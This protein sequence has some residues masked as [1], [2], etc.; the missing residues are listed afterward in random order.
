[1][2]NLPIWEN[3]HEEKSI[4]NMEEFGKG[5]KFTLYRSKGR[6]SVIVFDAG[7]G[8]IRYEAFHNKKD[9]T[10]SISKIRNDSGKTIEEIFMNKK[11]FDFLLKCFDI[12]NRIVS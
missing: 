6:A 1:M 10:I 5:K 9:H 8:L 12:E 3:T 11:D 2:K 4:L 7:K